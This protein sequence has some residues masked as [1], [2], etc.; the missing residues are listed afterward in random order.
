[1]VNQEKNKVN[2]KVFAVTG[3]SSGFG[4][5]M[6]GRFIER[7]YKV[8]VCSRSAENKYDGNLLSKKADVAILSDM[9]RFFQT[10]IQQWSRLDVIIV[11]AAI[12]IDGLLIKINED[13]I[14]RMIKT[15]LN[16][17][18]NSVKP[19]LSFLTENKQG[20][21]IAVTSFSGSAGTH[22]QSV[23]SATKA[24]LIGAVKSLAVELGEYGV[25]VN[26]VMPGFLDVGM[27]QRA[28][29][30][31]RDRA[32]HV[33]VLGRLACPYESAGFIEHLSGMKGVSG[34]IFNLD[35]RILSWI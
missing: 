6:V 13:A 5:I 22:G 20:H 12:N 24:G 11:N 16:G 33:N 34:Q 32:K 35:S 28:D 29:T 14:T 18:F 19:A 26:A 3:G 21:I 4:Q 2:E 1:M 15:N 30:Q 10:V 9:E 17:F 23:Y 25:C 7:G 8:G 31:I 27:G